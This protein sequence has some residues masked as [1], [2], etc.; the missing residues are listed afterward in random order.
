MYKSHNNHLIVLQTPFVKW[1][2]NKMLLVMM[3][4]LW[5]NIIG[6]NPPTNQLNTQGLPTGYWIYN[7]TKTNSK[8]EE[9]NYSD[10][11][12]EGVWKAWYANGNLKHEIT[13]EKGIA[14]GA[15]KFYYNDGSIREVG[16]WQEY[17]WV[18]NY[19]YYH[20]GGKPAY[21]W[22][23]NDQ[24]RRQGEQR[25]YY[26]DGTIKYRGSW[27]N[28]SITGQ[29]EVYDSS[30]KLTLL[31]N[32]NSEGEFEKLVTDSKAIEEFNRIKDQPRPSPFQ[33]TGNHTAYRSN[34]QIYQ[35]GY[36]LNGLLHNGQ[37]YVYDQNDEL[38]QVRVFE[39]GKLL[40]LISGNE[41]NNFSQ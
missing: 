15:A 3:L 36:Y 33:G 7:D 28:G 6:Q 23:Y 14:K 21:E 4:L 31:R 12:K 40:R 2:V 41:L 29:V 22:F 35:K 5:N 1:W 37:E 16:N 20:P 27:T 38:R 17:R 9:G 10:G 39:N 24:G 30:G 26:T 18:G 19:R 8:L 34:G 32:Y 11:V 25:Y 13:F